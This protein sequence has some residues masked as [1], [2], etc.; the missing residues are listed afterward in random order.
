MNCWKKIGNLF[1][2]CAEESEKRYKNI[3]T[4]YGRHLRKRKSVPSRSGRDAVPVVS[5]AFINLGW[6]E[7]HIT[8]RCA[9]ITNVHS[10]QN[11]AEGGGGGG[12]SRQ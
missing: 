6:L 3:R 8:Q 1:N 2:I 5:P 9:T 10:F 4:A 7:S 12:K 11:F